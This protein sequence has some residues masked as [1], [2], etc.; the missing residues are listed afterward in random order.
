M[1]WSEA[2]II[3]LTHCDDEVVPDTSKEFFRGV[4]VAKSVFETEVELVVVA[5]AYGAIVDLD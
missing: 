5:H 4:V 3:G 1:G 2:T